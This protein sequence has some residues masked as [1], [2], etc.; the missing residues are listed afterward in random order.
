MNGDPA[1][2][3][4]CTHLV[5]CYGH[6]VNNRNNNH[7]YISDLD[8]HEFYI[9]QLEESNQ[10]ILGFLGTLMNKYKIFFFFI[11]HIG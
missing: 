5:T 9:T 7:N 6:M 4:H 8:I 11:L 1:P 3:V 2:I 10:C